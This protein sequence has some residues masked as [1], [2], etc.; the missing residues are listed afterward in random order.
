MLEDEHSVSVEAAITSPMSRLLLSHQI[1]LLSRIPR[2]IAKEDDAMNVDED[3]ED[4]EE[5]EHPSSDRSAFVIPTVEPELFSPPEG[6]KT[7][8]PVYHTTLH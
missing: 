6:K 5:A 1:C 2:R 3:E 8:G 7:E 4:E